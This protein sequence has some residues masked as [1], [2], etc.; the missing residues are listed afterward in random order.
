ME[1]E[2]EASHCTYLYFYCVI[3]EEGKLLFCFNYVETLYRI[4]RREYSF[5]FCFFV[6]SLPRFVVTVFEKLPGIFANVSA[7]VSDYT[8]NRAKMLL[9][10]SKSII[11]LHLR[12]LQLE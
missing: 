9:D 2:V 11:T 5:Q 7:N 10:V 6:L 8:N 3:A 1:E 12:N 4:I